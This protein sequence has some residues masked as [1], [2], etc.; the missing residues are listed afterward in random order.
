MML[1]ICLQLRPLRS[2]PLCQQIGH[3]MPLDP[4]SN[5]WVGCQTSVP[6]GLDP[7]PSSLGIHEPHPKTQTTTQEETVPF[8]V[9]QNT[10][11][12]RKPHA[13]EVTQTGQ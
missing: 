2:L 9:V 12:W 7:K 5:P 1:A 13:P 3:A 4:I 10:Q 11:C 6:R 8:G